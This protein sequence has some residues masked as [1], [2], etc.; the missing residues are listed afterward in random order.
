LVF[1]E[2]KQIT[3]KHESLGVGKTCC[4]ARFPCDNTA[5]AYICCQ[6]AVNWCDEVTFFVFI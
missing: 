2:L 3:I 6:Y 4:I 5:L 1:R